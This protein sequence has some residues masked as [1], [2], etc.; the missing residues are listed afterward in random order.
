M[1]M[2]GLHVLSHLDDKDHALQCTICD[3]VIANDLTPALN[4]GLQDFAIENT[5]FVVQKL[6]A[7]KYSFIVSSAIASNQLFSR[8]PPFLL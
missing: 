6:I 8:P 2:A 5:E 7:K 1:K 4:P 3:H